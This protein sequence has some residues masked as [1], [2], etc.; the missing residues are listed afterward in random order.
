MFTNILQDEGLSVY[1]EIFVISVR[2]ELS[3]NVMKGTECFMSL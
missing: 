2:V 3:Y 1:L